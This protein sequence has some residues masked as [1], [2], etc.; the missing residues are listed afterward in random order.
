MVK[1]QLKRGKDILSLFKHA[2][3]LFKIKHI[4]IFLCH[5]F[6]INESV[7]IDDI[8]WLLLFMSDEKF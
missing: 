1:K 3:S 4:S 6:L 7:D 8:K 5:Q 2:F